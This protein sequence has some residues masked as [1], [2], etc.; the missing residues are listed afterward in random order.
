[1]RTST[2]RKIIYWVIKLLKYQETYQPYIVEKRREIQAVHWQR[3]YNSEEWRMMVERSMI[4]NHALSGIFSEL[5]KGDAIEIKVEPVHNS[6]MKVHAIL[7][8]I[9]P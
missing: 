5:E 2:K 6:D 3:I 1:M 8:Y 9:L 4:K 7:K